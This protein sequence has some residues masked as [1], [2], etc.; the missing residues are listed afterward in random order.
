MHEQLRKYKMEI[1]QTNSRSQVQLD[2]AVSGADSQP[3]RHLLMRLVRGSSDALS[4][5]LHLDMFVAGPNEFGFHASH[6]PPSLRLS[7][8][9]DAVFRQR[10][11]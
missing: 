9:Q 2:S 1:G 5:F 3:D 10:E 4:I 11:I 6:V 8:F 7:P